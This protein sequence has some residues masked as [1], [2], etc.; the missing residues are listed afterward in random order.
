MNRSRATILQ[1]LRCSI[2]I[3]FVFAGTSILAPAQSIEQRIDFAREIQPILANHCWSCHGPDE[4]SR[5]AELRLDVREQAIAKSAIV[6]GDDSTSELVHRI[7]ST[8]ED[9]K[10]P[11]SS[12]KKPLKEKQRE[13][14]RRWIQQG[15]TYSKHWAFEAPVRTTPPMQA[16]VDGNAA[17]P[18]D[19][20]VRDRLEREQ[21]AFSPQADRRTLLRRVTLD[22]TGLPPTLDEL[23]Q[24]L[25]DSP[26]TAY[27]KVVDRLLA[28]EQYAERMATI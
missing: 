8:D 3:F 15:A 7:E 16:Q 23:N 26:D 13:L 10:M 6:P 4:T 21:I 20:F 1:C 18:I 17:G 19:R 27:E 24:F 11:P 2:A 12:S 9:S 22:L 5:Q 25:S 14:L 28:S